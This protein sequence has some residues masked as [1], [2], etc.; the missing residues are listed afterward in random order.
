MRGLQF[1]QLFVSHLACV[2]VVEP[3]ADNFVVFRGERLQVGQSLLQQPHVRWGVRR[4]QRLR[5]IE[6]GRRG[7]HHRGIFG[8]AD[9]VGRTCLRAGY[10]VEPLS[11]GHIRHV[12]QRG[13]ARLD[14]DRQVGVAA[15]KMAET[16][17][18]ADTVGFSG[19]QRLVRDQRDQHVVVDERWR[20]GQFRQPLGLCVREFRA[21]GKLVERGLVELG[22]KQRMALNWQIKMGGVVQSTGALERVELGGSLSH[23]GSARLL[24]SEARLDD[25]AEARPGLRAPARSRFSAVRPER[26]WSHP[27]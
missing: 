25:L 3:G 1:W 12:G 11:L 10:R 27:S 9:T 13:H 22:L 15:R 20:S 17:Q 23:D 18:E 2:E 19:G 16:E 6:V 8:G 24:C 4:L 14:L 7:S 21:V 26:A 5:R